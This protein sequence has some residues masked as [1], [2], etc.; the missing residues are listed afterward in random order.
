MVG[1]MGPA[2]S[3]DSGQLCSIMADAELGTP[4]KLIF[5][6]RLADWLF[7]QSRAKPARE[8]VLAGAALMPGAIFFT[9]A[10]LFYSFGALDLVRLAVAAGIHIII[11][12]AYVVAGVISS[13]RQQG[14][15][16]GKKNPFG[17]TKLTKRDS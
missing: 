10:I 7:C 15:D 6:A 9:M 2:D 1:R 8:L 4:G 16:P 3:G 12:W 5:R 13:P 17:I 14:I 11:G